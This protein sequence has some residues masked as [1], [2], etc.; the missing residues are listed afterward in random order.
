MNRRVPAGRDS[1]RMLH[2]MRNAVDQGL[3]IGRNRINPG[4]AAAELYACR[5]LELG[6]QASHGFPRKA[7]RHGRPQYFLDCKKIEQN[8]MNDD[9]CC[10]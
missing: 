5:I 6:F 7:A 2:R 4:T 10:P 9:C 3:A 1:G 8:G